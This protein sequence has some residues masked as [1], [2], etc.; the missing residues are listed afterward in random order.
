MMDIIPT[1]TCVACNAPR[2]VVGFEP[3]S[4]KYD[5]LLMECSICRSVVRLAAKKQSDRK[6]RDRALPR[7]PYGRRHRP[8]FDA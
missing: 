8:S 4:R 1:Q 5:V 6:R 2:Q 3:L 7:R